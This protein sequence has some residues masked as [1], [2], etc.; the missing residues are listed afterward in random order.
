METK[1]Q[2]LEAPYTEAKRDAEPI[3]NLIREHPFLKDLSPHQHRLLADCAMRT[4]FR[5]GEV[6]FQQGD[7]ANRFY[8]IRRGKVAVEAW[9]KDRG[10]ITVQTLV[11]G[12]VLGWSWLYPP[13]YWQFGARA[14]EATDAIFIYGT[15]LREE[16]E[17]DHELGYELMKRV[18]AV[19]L[20]RLQATRR[21]LVGVPEGWLAD[22]AK[23]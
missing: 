13:Y 22:I 8:L 20:E 11:G 3:E 16:C 7:P 14:I 6:I 18:S 10:I 5:A 23:I 19:M 17:S 2:I 1:L 21:Q 4:Q 12:D 15:P 9:Q